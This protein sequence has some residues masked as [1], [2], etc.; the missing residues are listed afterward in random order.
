MFERLRVS[1]GSQELTSLLQQL[2]HSLAEPEVYGVFTNASLVGTIA[3]VI[4][5]T[6][7]V[8]ILVYD[9][10]DSDVKAGSLE[11]IREAGVKVITFDEFIS[12]G[13]EK[14]REPNHP[15]PEDIACIM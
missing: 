6:P 2:Q 13:K 12:M 3:S 8:K 5:E 4:K 10:K 1:I 11:K 14:P 7:T 9:G 15:E